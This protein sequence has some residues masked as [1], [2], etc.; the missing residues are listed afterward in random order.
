MD[1][2][3]RTSYEGL[4]FD[5][6]YRGSEAAQKVL[7]VGH[8]AVEQALHQAES[9]GSCLA[10]VPKEGLAW[11]LLVYQARDS[12]TGTGAH[13]RVA[14]L[15]VEVHT[16]EANPVC[17]LRDWELLE[18]LNGMRLGQAARRASSSPPATDREGLQA[19]IE[20]AGHHL[21]QSLKDL[22]PAYRYPV[23]DVLAVLW[24]RR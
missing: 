22:F 20:L 19:A 24:P 12:L 2:G 23:A 21:R 7:G 5:R 15:G 17:I 3:V 1:P 18:R 4:V 9:T 8:R 13:A 14:V 6:N 11:P 10:S 16:G